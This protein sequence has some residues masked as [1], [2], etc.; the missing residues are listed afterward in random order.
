[1]PAYELKVDL[2]ALNHLGINLYSN[3]PAVLSELIANAWDAD[4]GNV[5]LDF[6]TNGAD[7]RIIVRDDGC[8]M[9]EAE[10]NDKFLNVGYRRRKSG[11]DTTPL[12]GRKVMGRKG[13]GKLSVFSIANY[14]EVYT[15]KSGKTLGLVLDVEQIR[16]DIN[17]SNKH[18]PDP[19]D[20]IPP[21]YEIPHESGTTIVLTRLKKRVQSSID[22][23]LEKRVAR[24]FSVF[25]DE[26]RVCVNGNRVSITDRGYFHKLEYA[27]IY[28]E[29]WETH[30]AHL[31]DKS[32][33]TVRNN[34]VDAV[35][36][37]E[38]NGWI[39][40]VGESGSLQ[41]GNDNLNKLAILSRGKI[42][43]E[44]ILETFRE[45]GLYTKYLIGEIEAD[46]LDLTNEDDI[47]TSSRQDFLRDDERYANLCKFV[48]DELRFIQKERARFKS[49][50]GVEKAK[51]IPA[52]RQWLETLKGDARKAAERLFAR[53]NAIVTDDQ[54]R[55]TLFKHGILAFEHLH[56]KEKLNELDRLEIAN[57]EVAVRLFSE[58]DDIEASWY[59]Q[60]TQGRLEV[61]QKL[62]AHVEDNALEKIIQEHVHSHLWL[63][64]PSWDRAT[65]TPQM[66]KTIKE[67]FMNLQAKSTN[68]ERTGRIDIIYK[69]SSGKHII[70]E[71]K[72]ASVKTDT[73]TLLNQ[74]DKY[75]TAVKKAARNAGDNDSV[76]TICLVGSDLTDWVTDELREESE[77]TLQPKNIRVV[78]YQQLIHDAE[79]NYRNYL[80]KSDD[81]G[82]INN[83]LEEIESF[84]PNSN[85]LHTS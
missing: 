39:G 76:E 20:P 84:Q 13:I 85:S 70:I 37:H 80:E 11:S 42:A 36:S 60:I 58:L 18:C 26:F 7:T 53:I 6:N 49:E 15:R 72:R 82:R 19:I 2:N 4:A 65:E 21:D 40:L 33:M 48:V 55:K 67:E 23:N 30:L 78:T 74:V 22:T 77:K 66:E 28:G 29:G 59:Y 54:H 1:M 56:F 61:V 24:R 64:D 71:L 57:L 52:V 43:S 31:S 47:A 8:G 10:I 14:I 68:G 5:D 45:G 27:L 38:V 9:N 79:I 69:K 46:F 34:E 75:R 44:D 3:V 16:T 35:K 12:K 50:E 62:T 32:R 51:E 63:L 83:L 41:D 73:S 25:S 17:D 81:R